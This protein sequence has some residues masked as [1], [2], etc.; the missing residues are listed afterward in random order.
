MAE[1]AISPGNAV[2]PLVSLN[3]VVF[4]TE[5]T[6]LDT[7]KARII[8][9]GAIK[10]SSGRL[11]ETHTF[12]RY[13]NPGEPIPAANTAI[14]GIRDED[15]SQAPGFVP[16]NAEFDAWCGNALMI[17]YSTGYDLAIFRR[18]YRLAGIAWTPPRT[19][20][21]HDKTPGIL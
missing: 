20:D 6:G 9:V 11:D 14:H 13:V 7:T 10:I 3:A 21:V 16:L 1:T 5:T 15:V 19:L 17:G 8:Q 18:E 12:E 2:T 4:D